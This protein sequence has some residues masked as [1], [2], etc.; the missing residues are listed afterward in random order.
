MNRRHIEPRLMG[1]ESGFLNYEIKLRETN[2]ARSGWVLSLPPFLCLHMYNMREY[3]YKIFCTI[4]FLLNWM[5]FYRHVF[6]ADLLFR[7]ELQIYLLTR[8]TVP[9]ALGRYE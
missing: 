1:W 2:V 5:I 8:D 4:Y 6:S 9:T 3:M 7:A